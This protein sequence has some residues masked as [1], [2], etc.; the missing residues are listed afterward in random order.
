MSRPE[1]RSNGHQTNGHPD[2][3]LSLDDL[4]HEAESLRTVL[5]ELCARVTQFGMNLKRH[6]RRGKAIEG[7]LAALRVKLPAL[8]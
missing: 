4:I 1:D 6:R 2:N 7:A 3:S 5:A 8:P